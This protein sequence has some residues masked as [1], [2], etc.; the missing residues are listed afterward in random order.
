MRR[1]VVLL[2]I[3]ATLH[4]ADSPRDAATGD[5]EKLQG[6]W[7]ATEFID[8]GKKTP[9]EGVSIEF[10][11]DKITT[12]VRGQWSVSGTYAIDSEKAPAT[13]DMTFENDG[14]KAT[15][16]AIYELRGDE[17]KLCH[18]KTGAQG[19]VRPKVF[20]ATAKTVFATLKRY[21]P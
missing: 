7:R 20:E 5:R 19:G 8:G 6:V 14:R 13:M 10:K 1:T 17:L 3:A 9:A 18:P 15:V 16:P 12:T 2:M 11:G 4:A 21:K